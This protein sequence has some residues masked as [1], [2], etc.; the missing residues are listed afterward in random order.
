MASKV[1]SKI[2][3]ITDLVKEVK[4]KD[5]DV[6]LSAP[7]VSMTMPQEEEG[8]GGGF[9]DSDDRTLQRV[10]EASRFST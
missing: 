10:L 3:E 5:K 9:R 6:V 4:S 1:D 2:K 8:Q 7:Y